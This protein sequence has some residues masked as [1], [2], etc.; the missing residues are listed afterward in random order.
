MKPAVAFMSGSL[1]AAAG[2]FWDGKAAQAAPSFNCARAATYVEIAICGDSELSRLDRILNAEYR[3]AM[4]R[5][6]RRGRILLEDEQATWVA[7]RDQCGEYFCVDDAYRTRIAY[8]RAVG[9][10]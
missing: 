5:L 2:F 10:F 8:L 3:A 1:L 9:R 7:F 6:N 4:D